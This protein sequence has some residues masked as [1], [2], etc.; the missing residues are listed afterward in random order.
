MLEQQVV[1]DTRVREGRGVLLL[2]LL[3]LRRGQ[4]GRPRG[5]LWLAVKHCATVSSEHD[6]RTSAGTAASAA[7]GLKPRSDGA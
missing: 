3:K 7:Q 1:S 5:I 2:L 4:A 6:G